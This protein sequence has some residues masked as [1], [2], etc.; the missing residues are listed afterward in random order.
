MSA[1]AAVLIFAFVWEG[2]ALIHA[3]EEVVDVAKSLEL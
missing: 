2:A 1:D 3:Q